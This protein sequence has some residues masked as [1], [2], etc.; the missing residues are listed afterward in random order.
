MCSLPT[1]AER[2]IKAF[3]G[4]VVA[5]GPFPVP[6]STKAAP[7]LQKVGNGNCFLLENDFQLSY[8]SLPV[9]W[10]PSPFSI[11]NTFSEDISYAGTTQLDMPPPPP[12]EWHHVCFFWGSH[13]HQK[14]AI[15]HQMVRKG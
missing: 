6:W 11:S 13:L 2:W 14:A 10:V 7:S 3:S 5:N 8:H 9:L 1:T 12:R 4:K 15:F